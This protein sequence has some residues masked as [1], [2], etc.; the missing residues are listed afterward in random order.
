[1]TL[2]D[3]TSPWLAA[4]AMPCRYPASSANGAEFGEPVRW[5]L[6]QP[7]NGVAV[8]G[9]RNEAASGGAFKPAAIRAAAPTASGR[10][11]ANRLATNARHSSSGPNR[12]ALQTRLPAAPR[13]LDDSLVE[14]APRDDRQERQPDELNRNQLDREGPALSGGTSGLL[15]KPVAVSPIA[16][17]AIIAV[18]CWVLLAW[19]ISELLL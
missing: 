6:K 17:A 12:V 13:V 4:Y 5:I 18:G 16:L 7:Q 1:L 8:L 10:P 11:S 14:Q 3:C 19:L 15:A 9:E 2:P